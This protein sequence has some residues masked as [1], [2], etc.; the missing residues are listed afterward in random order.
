MP[1]IVKTEFS[2]RILFLALQV[3][4]IGCINTLVFSKKSVKLVL[5]AV[6]LSTI[7]TLKI[8]ALRCTKKKHWFAGYK[9]RPKLHHILVLL[10]ELFTIFWCNSPLII[11]Q[12]RTNFCSQQIGAFFLVQ[13]RVKIFRLIAAFYSFSTLKNENI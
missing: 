3:F 12:L 5:F 9:S 11:V 1:K 10:L 8:F 7:Y 2:R 6:D 13:H 4:A